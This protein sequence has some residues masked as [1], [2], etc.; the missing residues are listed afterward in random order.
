[1]ANKT[2][3]SKTYRIYLKFTKEW[4]EVSEELYRE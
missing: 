2:N 3:Q 4:V 1:M